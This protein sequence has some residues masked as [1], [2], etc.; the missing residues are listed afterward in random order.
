MDTTFVIK[1]L[2]EEWEGP[3]SQTKFVI[4]TEKDIKHICQ[5]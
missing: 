4:K 1:V 5:E 3:I 2:T